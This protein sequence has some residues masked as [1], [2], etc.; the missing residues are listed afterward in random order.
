MGDTAAEKY[1]QA[2][3]RYLRSLGLEPPDWVRPG[4]DPMSL[5]YLERNTRPD[6]WRIRW[7]RFVASVRARLH[8]KRTA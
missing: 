2:Q 5:I 7:A 1:E 8:R 4:F 6:P 3:D